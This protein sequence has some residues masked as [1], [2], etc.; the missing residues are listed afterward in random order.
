MRES[1]RMRETADRRIRGCERQRIRERREEREER[2]EKREKREK[3]IR[4]TK[5]RREDERDSGSENQKM[6]E[7]LAADQRIR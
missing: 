7:T 4:E 1:W 5:H 3:W 2:R 6:R